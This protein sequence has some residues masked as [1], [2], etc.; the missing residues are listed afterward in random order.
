MSGWSVFSWSQMVWKCSRRYVDVFAAVTG[1]VLGRHAGRYV[2][3]LLAAAFQRD[4][5]ERG[6]IDAVPAGGQQ[7]VVLV[8]RRLYA[9]EGLGHVG[10]CVVFHGHCTGLVTDDHVVLEKGAGVLCDGF[11]RSAGG[12]PGGA[13][14]CVGVAHG[15]DVG[16]LLVH[17]GM[18]NEAGRFTA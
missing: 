6:R 5:P 16:V 12:A 4:E 15:D 18:Q 14:K 2:E 11:D 17:V 1:A 13:I 7:A 8:Q 10:A 3:L 9:L